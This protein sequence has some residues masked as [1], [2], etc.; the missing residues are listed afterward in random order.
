MKYFVCFLSEQV[1]LQILAVPVTVCPLILN[2]VLPL[3]FILCRFFLQTSRD[4][5]PQ[6]SVTQRKRQGSICVRLENLLKLRD[7]N[8]S[9][10]S[11]SQFF[12]L[13]FG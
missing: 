7:T 5:I 8:N 4:L 10:F 13:Q 2:P 1:F 12:S 11:Y 3:L 6:V 9:L